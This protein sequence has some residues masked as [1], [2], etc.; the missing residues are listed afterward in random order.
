MNE[1]LALPTRRGEETQVLNNF[2]KVKKKYLNA[3]LCCQII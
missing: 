2:L 3:T 1:K